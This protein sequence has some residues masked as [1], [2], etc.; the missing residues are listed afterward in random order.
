MSGVHV[1]TSVKST[2]FAVAPACSTARSAALIGSEFILTGDSPLPDSCPC[3]NPGIIGIHQPGNI[4]VGYFCSGTQAPIPTLEHP[5]FDVQSI[6]WP[7]GRVIIV[8]KHDFLPMF[9]PIKRSTRRP[10]R[11]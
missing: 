6:I 1:V 9:L 10:G 11:K 4:G 8:I 2:S 7:T 5:W 3:N